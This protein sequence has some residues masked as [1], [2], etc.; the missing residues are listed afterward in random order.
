[1]RKTYAHENAGSVLLMQRLQDESLITLLL[2]L[3]GL[4]S[5]ITQIR[6]SFK[7]NGFK[8][9]LWFILLALSAGMLFQTQLFQW[10]SRASWAARVN[11]KELGYNELI[12]KAA[13]HQEFVSNLRA[14]LSLIHI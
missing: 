14:Q 4:T 7:S 12:R 11:G 1:M 9:A 3:K 6:K 8:I 5:M 2:V 10:S 13:M